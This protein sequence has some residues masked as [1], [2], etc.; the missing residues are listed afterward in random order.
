MISPWMN[1][2]A[3]RAEKTLADHGIR[4]TIG[5]E[6]TFIPNDPQGPEWSYSAVGP[7][8]L[9]YAKR[10]A[11]ELMKE[12]CAGAARFYCPG[13]LYPGE[14]N[15]R[16]VVRLISNRDGSPVFT[17]PKRGKALTPSSLQDFADTLARELGVPSH[18]IGF[19]DPNGSGI[20]VLVMPLDHDGSIWRSA[21]WPLPK[22]DRKLSTAEGPAGLRLPLH[23]MPEGLP[24]RVLCIDRQGGTITIFVPP[25]LQNAFLHLLGATER[26]AKSR[27]VA[28]L[29][30]HGYT[31]QD[32][33]G[34]WSV[35]GLAAD[36]GVL[37]INLPPCESWQAYA[38]WMEELF[39]SGHRAGMRTWKESPWEHPQGSGGGNHL[40]WGGPSLDE[41]PF[42]T[43]PLWLAN[44]LRYWQHHPSL[45]YLFTGCYVGASSQA[46]RPDESARDL[47]DIDMAYTFIESLSEGDHR[48]LIN[49]TLRHIQ[50][51]VTGNSHRS[52]ISLDKFW[53]TAFPSGMLGLIEFRAIEALPKSEWSSA[54]A[55]LWSCLAS[56]LLENPPKRSLK[57][58]S[59]KLHDEYFLPRRLWDDLE[60]IFADL[61]K[62]GYK[63]DRETYRAIW[64]WRFPV[65]LEWK[66]GRASLTVR[67]A[68]ES[69]PLLSETPV[70]GGSTSRFVDTS[71]QR[72]EF[73]TSPGFSS[74]YDI[75]VAGRPLPL[76]AQPNE[77]SL[78][79]LRYRRTNLYPSL[80]PGIPTQLPLAVTIVNRK[81]GRAVAEFVMGV[82][83]IDFTPLDKPGLTA[84]GGKP[85]RGG[86]R[87]D[88]TCDLRLA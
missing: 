25:L 4:F 7:T 11:D 61:E 47:Y 40:L 75:Y 79:G 71:M 70:E 36:P 27:G 45:A 51:D 42:F 19:T 64:D 59:T 43:R 10:F 39:A 44:V 29:E 23:L 24:R 35:L 38:E 68:L 73:L 62:T 17:L 82:D 34:K 28:N 20:E 26:A 37:E 78:A 21:R 77:T 69:W 72:L 58:F 33:E 50:I 8:K 9:S 76:A 83:E 6:P 67:K 81:N 87:G 30:F 46:P 1:E 52:E 18:W 14:T 15:P 57:R 65:L 55:L 63:L 66:S 60:E 3:A 88:L 13:K 54:V 80:H 84:L 5:G 2:A 49:E 86:R 32:E 41:H 31:P 85:C 53:N 16:W 74:Q 48:S 22:G 56:H 12:R